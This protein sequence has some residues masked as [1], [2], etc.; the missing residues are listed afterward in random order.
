[1]IPLS[2]IEQRFWSQN[3]EDGILNWLLRGV[4]NPSRTFVEIG[5]SD[6]GENNTTALA[7]LGYRGVAIDAQA[8][9][10]QRYHAFATRC[11]FADRVAARRHRVTPT[12]AADL[13][14]CRWFIARP[15]L[16]SI[17]VDGPDWHIARALLMAGFRPAV[18]V[19]EYQATFGPRS[20]LVSPWPPARLAPDLKPLGKSHVWGASLTAWRRLLGAYQYHFVTVNSTGVNAF[21]VQ[22]DLCDSR[23]LEPVE[24][25]QWAD[26]AGW[27]QHHGPWPERWARVAHLDY[28]E[29]PCT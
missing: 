10:I 6:G 11:G 17:D 16:F 18:I 27:T 14:E 24:W 19:A 7:L 26:N 9:R 8:E 29:M 3:G 23:L 15:D 5:A 4:K 12:L 22:P 13:L 28:L 2:L 25:P 20:A 1:M 21:F